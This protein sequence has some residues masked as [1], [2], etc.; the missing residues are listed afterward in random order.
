M[1][2][3]AINS[4]NRSEP[5]SSQPEFAKIPGAAP[6]KNSG[7]GTG[8]RIERGISLDEA[9]KIAAEDPSIKYFFYVTADTLVLEIEQEAFQDLAHFNPIDE[10]N[11]PIGIVQ[12]TRYRYGDGRVVDG[13]ARVFHSGDVVFFNR[14]DMWLGDAN[15]YA[16]TY[17]KNSN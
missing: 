3:Q 13:Y 12:H 5:L 8:F 10:H 17:V 14:E 9:K 16:D 11:D 2:V 4:P 6:Y 15:G 7:W 1:T